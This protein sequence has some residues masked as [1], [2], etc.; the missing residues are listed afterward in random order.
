MLAWIWAAHPGTAAAQRIGAGSIFSRVDDQATEVTKAYAAI[1]DGFYGVGKGRTLFKAACDVRPDGT[2]NITLDR[3]A[4]TAQFTIR[5]SVDDSAYNAWKADAHRRIEAVGM[6][7]QFSD[8]EDPKARV[9]GGKPYR[10]GDNEE[11][12]IR[13]W[14]KS[15]AP[16]KAELVVR[17]DL[18]DAGGAVVKRHDLPIRA[19]RRLG[20]AS[21]PLPLHHL[22]R[23]M[24]LSG[25][26]FPWGTTEDSYAQFPLTDLTDDFLN[27]VADVK[28]MVVDDEILVAEREEAARLARERAEAARLA[29][30]R[31]EREEAPRIAREKAEREARELVEAARLARE[32]A[33]RNAMMPP[34]TRVDEAY[35]ALEK[36]A[37]RGLRDKNV[38][39]GQPFNKSVSADLGFWTDPRDPKRKYFRVRVAS[40]PVNPLPIVSKDIVFLLDVSGSIGNDRLG[41]CRNAVSDALGRLNPGDRFN[42]V[43]FRDKVSYAFSDTAWREVD[44]N[45]V[46]EARKWLSALKAHGKTDVFRALKSVLALPRDPARPIV[47]FAM[48]D[49]DATSGMVRS[50][51][52]ISRF[53]EQNG[54][55]VSVFMYGVKPEANAY[56]MGMLTRYNRGGWA[57]HKGLRWNAAQGVPGFSKKFEKP[58]LTDV[59]MTFG[60]S[61]RAETYPKLAANLCE[62]AP[63]EIYG[64]CPADQQELVFQM[65][66]LNAMTPFEGTFTL[67]FASAQPLDDEVRTAWATRRLYELIAAYAR[68]PNTQLRADIHAFAEAYGI[69]IP[70]DKEMK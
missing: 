64:V 11:A 32:K 6:S 56:L 40:N 65:R 2:P 60:A 55:L 34:P 46:E 15:D 48:T 44:V 50:V 45:S 53:S 42:V 41:S 52:I 20:F 29:R 30:E 13:R 5:L 58:V 10:F 51:E 1:H 66:G 24:D 47:A 22:N 27:S 14:E 69:E 31:A 18:V 59:T 54:G 7:V 4:G 12:A 61:S 38:S 62:D 16:K 67:P 9:I 35:L 25:S 28:C 26:R 36:A 3:A 21:Y 37:I 8:F 57:C 17:V 68:K 19:F 70:Y 23:L 33:K 49:G 43:A 63:I 39:M